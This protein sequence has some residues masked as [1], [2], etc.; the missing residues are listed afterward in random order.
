M[1]GASIDGRRESIRAS[2][3]KYKTTQTAIQSL[4]QPRGVLY[5]TQLVAMLVEQNEVVA[6]GKVLKDRLS[7]GL[8]LLVGSKALG[9]ANI[10]NIGDVEARVVAYTLGVEAHKAV[11][12]TRVGLADNDKFDIHRRVSISVFH[13]PAAPGVKI[14]R[15][16]ST[17]LNH[18]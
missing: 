12:L 16:V 8:L 7:L 13:S 3:D 9:V 6:I 14:G 4:L 2:N 5:A 10:G 11:Y 1:V 15:H 17:P 18:S